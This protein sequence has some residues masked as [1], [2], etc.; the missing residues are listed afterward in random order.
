MRIDHVRVSGHLVS[1]C[2]FVAMVCIGLACAVAQGQAPVHQHGRAA[3]SSQSAN[4]QRA[5][6]HAPRRPSFAQRISRI[7][8]QSLVSPANWGQS[9]GYSAVGGPLRSFGGGGCAVRACHTHYFGNPE[10]LGGVLQANMDMQID[11][12]KK[13]RL[14]M[15]EYDFENDPGRDQAALNAAG[16]RKLERLV[17]VLETTGHPLLIE[18]S[19]D[20]PGIAE[21]RRMHVV[22]VLETE[23]YFSNAHAQVAVKGAPT[24]GLRGVEAVEIDRNQINLTR[25]RG[26]AF[27]S[28]GGS[29]GSSGFSPTSSSS[30]GSNRN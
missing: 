29:T 20:Y 25:S 23:M 6:H 12:G 3:Q 27:S 15:Y 26:T 1:C 5:V 30:G 2:R 18:P 10:P 9:G 17:T 8:H 13:A 4:V 16:R 7:S 21:S 14:V 11:N 28:T 24:L 19:E 22:N